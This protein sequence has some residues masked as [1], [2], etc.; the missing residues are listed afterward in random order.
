[1]PKIIGEGEIEEI[2]R[3][4]KYYIRHHLGKDKRT[5]K[6]IRSPKRVVHGNKAEARRQLELY[7]K[8]LE[9]GYSDPD[10]LKVGEYGDVWLRRRREAGQ[11]SPLTLR[12]DAQELQKVKD[13]FGDV[14]L[15]D[16]TVAGINAAYDAMRREGWSASMIHQFNGC[17]RLILK[18]ACKEMIIP[19]NPCDNVDA[20]RQRRRERKALTLEQATQLAADLREA[21]RDG[22]I[23]AVWL[24]LAT[25][26]R[27]GEA[28][29]LTWENVDLGRRRIHIVQQYANDLRIRAP[30]SENSMRWIG[31]DDGTVAFLKEW[32]AQQARE[33]EIQGMDQ[34]PQTPVC[35][36]STFG[37]IDPNTFSRWRRQF[38]VEHGLGHYETIKQFMPNVGRE[39]PKRVYVGY[40]FHELRHTQATLLIGQ[41]SDVKTV[42][43]RLG[44]SSASLTM[45]VYAHAIPANDE[46]AAGVMGE[47]LSGKGGELQTTSS[48]GPLPAQAP[49]V[50]RELIGALLAQLPPEKLVEILRHAS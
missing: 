15:R 44:H 4:K 23:V 28:L 45:D 11:H 34:G 37:L 6:Y 12:K 10:K 14:P 48:T 22:R 47:L 16:M 49:D 29:G 25:G 7:R 41:G 42:Q 31:I 3:G 43:H 17:L 50:T 38:F 21:K 33:M 39:V 2:V 1:M 27:R 32:R 5:G 30:K 40:N 18:S 46:A 36:S 26:I 8:E 19:S 20:P 24:A 35:T 9:L 13:R